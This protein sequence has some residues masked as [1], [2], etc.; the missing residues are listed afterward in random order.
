MDC[1][2]QVPHRNTENERAFPRA[3]VLLHAMLLHMML[4]LLC[5]DF[6]KDAAMHCHQCSLYK[7][8]DSNHLVPCRLSWMAHQPCSVVLTARTSSL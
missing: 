6:S 3:M 1:S 2:S 7:L 5:D 8:I 4:I